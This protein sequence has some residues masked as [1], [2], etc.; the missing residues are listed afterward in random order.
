MLQSYFRKERRFFGHKK[1]FLIQYL[2]NTG[3]EFGDCLWMGNGIMPVDMKAMIA[4]TLGEILKRKKLDKITVK[5][6]VDA[7]HISRQTFYYHFQ[8]IMDVVEWYQDQALQ[9]SI[10]VSLA[11]PSFREAVKGLVFETFRQ[12][13]M[14]RQVLS[15]N[16]R[17]EIEQLFVRSV[18]TYL[19]EVLRKKAPQIT[20]S[21]ADAEAILCFYSNGVVGMMLDGLNQKNPDI[22]LLAEQMYKVLTGEILFRFGEAH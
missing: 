18:R 12:K 1:C 21:P 17:E 10:E 9:K 7:C 13:E 6:L 22:E 5:E 16:R 20:L 8:D 2:K 14:I 19:Q 15:S 4:D 11:A 3:R